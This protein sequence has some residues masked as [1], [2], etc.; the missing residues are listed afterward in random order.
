MAQPTRRRFLSDSFAA[1]TTFGVG[2]ALTGLSNRLAYGDAP[3]RH[4]NLQPVNDEATGLPLLRLPEGFRYLTYG[5]KGDTMSD[6]TPTPGVARWDG[7]DCCR[8]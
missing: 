7:G 4:S 6:G 3:T 2:A 1:A 8:G 5:W